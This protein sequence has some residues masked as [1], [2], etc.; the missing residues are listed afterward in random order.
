MSVSFGLPHLIASMAEKPELWGMGHGQD[1]QR[2]DLGLGWTYY[3][4]AR[5]LRPRL[6]VV[7]GSWRGFVPLLI[8]QAIQ[9]GGYGGRLI[10]IDPSLVDDH[11]RGDVMAYFAGFGITC[12][13]HHRQTSQAFIA[14]DE[15]SALTVDLLFV[16][17]LHTDEQCRLEYEAFEPRLSE[18]ALTFFH[19]ST[20]RVHSRLYGE[21]KAYTHTVWR[22]MEELRQREDLEVLELPISQG[23]TLVRRGQPA[24][25]PV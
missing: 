18:N 8:A 25:P 14:R 11:W 3:G 5:S 9:D 19:D 4:L 6:A 17:G 10:F 2:Q 20:S 21:D 23:V 13:E 15:F 22:Y 1:P 12:I 7:I 16:D 24:Q